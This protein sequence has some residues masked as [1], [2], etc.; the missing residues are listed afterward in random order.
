MSEMFIGEI[1]LFA[2][3]FAP[4]FWA[5]CDGQQLPIAQNQALFSL[6]G[7]TYGGNGVTTFALPDLRG[8]VAVGYGSLQGGGSYVQGQAGG[9]E[10]VTLLGSQLPMHTHPVAASTGAATTNVPTSAFPAAPPT[11]IYAS[12]TGLTST[13]MTTG[14]GGGQAHSN[15]QPGL[16]V[17]ACIAISGIFPSRN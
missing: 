13:A 3:N 10:T 2:F 12:A 16:V 14:A 9:A 11:G 4:K 8:R 6:L 1:R 15:L 7:T 5:T 17:N